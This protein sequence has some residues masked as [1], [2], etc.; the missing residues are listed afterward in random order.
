MRKMIPARTEIWCDGCGQQM[1]SEDIV[2]EMSLRVH[3]QVMKYELCK[4]C[5]ERAKRVIPQYMA[6]PGTSK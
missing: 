5:S 4:N 3:P 1:K 6:L 2:G